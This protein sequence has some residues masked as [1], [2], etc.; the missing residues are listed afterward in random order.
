MSSFVQRLLDLSAYCGVEHDA[1]DTIACVYFWRYVSL[2][3][4][5]EPGYRCGVDDR[6]FSVYIV[7]WVLGC[8]RS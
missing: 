4:E 5:G 2:I 6:A 7:R 8:R 3:A 1:L